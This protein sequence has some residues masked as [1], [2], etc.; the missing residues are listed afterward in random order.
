MGER[1]SITVHKEGW[2]FEEQP[3]LFRHWAGHHEEMQALV[4]WLKELL[5]AEGPGD[6]YTRRDPD[7]VMALL[8][9]LAAESDG[10]SA[11]LATT[12]RG[13]DDSDHGHYVLDLDR[14]ELQHVDRG[15]GCT[16]CEAEGED[17]G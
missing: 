12:R 13:G 10:F 8:V 14:L 11:Y 15:F 4:D 7:A 1:G 9:R 5:P 3:V 17:D 2:P 6:P 16:V